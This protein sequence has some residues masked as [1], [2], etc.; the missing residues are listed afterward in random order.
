MPSY[1]ICIEITLGKLNVSLACVHT[2]TTLTPLYIF[3]AVTRSG[4]NECKKESRMGDRK[5]E[6]IKMTKREVK[7]SEYKLTSH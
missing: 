3:I 5:K 4:V 2:N 1:V 7:R 6:K